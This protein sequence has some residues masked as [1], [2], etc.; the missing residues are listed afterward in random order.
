MELVLVVFL[1]SLAL[2]VGDQTVISLDGD[3]WF[4]SDSSGRFKEVQAT[5]PGQVHLDLLYVRS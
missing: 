4:L 3:D 2:V 5:V 1:A